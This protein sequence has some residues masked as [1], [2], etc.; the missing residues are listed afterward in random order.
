M[1]KAIKS[2]KRGRKIKITKLIAGGIGSTWV[3]LDRVNPSPSPTHLA[4]ESE[5]A[6]E[7]T[8]LNAVTRYS[9]ETELNRGKLLEREFTTT[10][11]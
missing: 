11:V 6:K 8:A 3:H 10:I 9:R 2:N 7:E 4:R 1:L 5:L